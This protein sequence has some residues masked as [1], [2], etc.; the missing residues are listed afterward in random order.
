M[1]DSVDSGDHILKVLFFCFFFDFTFKNS[2]PIF[3]SPHNMIHT[4]SV[5]AVIYHHGQFFISDQLLNADEDYLDW[6]FG[7]NFAGD[8]NALGSATVCGPAPL[9]ACTTP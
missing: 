1:K 9:P 5:A 6:T 3:R 4:D 7:T 8:L 2:I